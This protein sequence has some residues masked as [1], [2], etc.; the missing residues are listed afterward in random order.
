MYVCVCVFVHARG[1]CVCVFVR[2]HA[3]VKICMRLFRTTSTRLSKQLVE[4]SSRLMAVGLQPILDTQSFLDSPLLW[5]PLGWRLL[6]LWD[7][8]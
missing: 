3:N 1:V 7:L 6:I 4:K 2:G 8:L 5:T